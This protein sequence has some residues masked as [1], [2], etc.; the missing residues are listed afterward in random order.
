MQNME[1]RELM[2]KRRIRHYEIAEKLGINETTFCRWLRKEFTPERKQQVIAA[3][4]S[5]SIK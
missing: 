3:I 2:R 5:I 1:I 4:E